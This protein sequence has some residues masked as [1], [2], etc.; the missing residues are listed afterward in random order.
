MMCAFFLGRISS[1]A[2]EPTIL[3]VSGLLKCRAWKAAVMGS[4]TFEAL[5]KI[6]ED[7]NRSA[8]V[9]GGPLI[10]VD[11]SASALMYAYFPEGRVYH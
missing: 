6:S 5:D 2:E 10:V 7:E 8:R 4:L 11:E 9:D 3:L 1:S